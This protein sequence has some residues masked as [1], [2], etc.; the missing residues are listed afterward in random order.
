MRKGALMA[1]Q[2]KHF[3]HQRKRLTIFT[4]GEKVREL[5]IPHPTFWMNAE[6]HILDIEARPN[7]CLMCQQKTIPRAG[8]RRFPEKPMGV[9]GTHLW[10]YKR[11][12]AAGIVPTGTTSG[13]RMHKARH[14]AGQRVLDATGN[15]KA[16]QKL[17]LY[18]DDRRRV[19]GLGHRPARRDDVDHPRRGR[20]SGHMNVPAVKN[21]KPER[22]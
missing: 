15:L 13:E 2:F 17:R 14:T 5:P 21:R 20:K 19:R 1:V 12:E 4:K 11:L 10:W 8:V 22:T 16:A 6:R 3:D 18:L 7:H 9:H